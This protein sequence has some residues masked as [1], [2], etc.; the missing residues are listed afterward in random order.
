MILIVLILV[1]GIGGWKD[2]ANLVAL[3]DCCFSPKSQIRNT[4]LAF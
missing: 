4:D 2:E 1:D 3:S